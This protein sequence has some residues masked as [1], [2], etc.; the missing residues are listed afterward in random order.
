MQAYHSCADRLQLIPASAKRAKGVQFEAMLDRSGATASELINV[1]LKARIRA[2]ASA[3]SC[4]GN[5]YH[6]LYGS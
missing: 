5:Q 4:D 6:E 2:A 3:F 1:D